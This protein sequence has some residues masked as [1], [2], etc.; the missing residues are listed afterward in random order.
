MADSTVQR[1][2][3]TMLEEKENGIAMVNKEF[4]THSR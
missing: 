4:E 3:D 1:V 2:I